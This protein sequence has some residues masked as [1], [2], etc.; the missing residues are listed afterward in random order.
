MASRRHPSWQP[1]EPISCVDLVVDSLDFI[2]HLTAIATGAGG[3]I[4]GIR[5]IGGIRGMGWGWSGWGNCVMPKNRGQ[6][7]LQ[8]SSLL[9]NVTQVGVPTRIIAERVNKVLVDRLVL[10]VRRA[11]RDQGLDPQAFGRVAEH[12]GAVEQQRVTDV[13]QRGGTAASCMRGTAGERWSVTLHCN[14]SY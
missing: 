13:N 5:S 9:N 8:V 7:E 14:V 4:G 2:H 6:P 1:D 12:I 3:G 11:P 10:F